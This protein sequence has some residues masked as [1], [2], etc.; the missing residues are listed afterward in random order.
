MFLQSTVY[1]PVHG[2]P[3][4]MALCSY[5][6]YRQES[7]WDASC[8]HAQHLRCHCLRL[9]LCGVRPAPYLQVAVY[10]PRVIY[11]C[12]LRIRLKKLYDSQSGKQ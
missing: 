3:A 2:P 7:N 11:R 12:R 10:L 1:N 9:L 5:S 6:W 4:R 8:A